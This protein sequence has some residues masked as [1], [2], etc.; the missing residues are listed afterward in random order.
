[1]RKWSDDKILEWTMDTFPHNH[2]AQMLKVEEELLE[3]EKAKR[4]VFQ[5]QAC[6]YVEVYKESADVVIAAIGLRRYP[7]YAAIGR[8]IY[9]AVY[10]PIR[11][12]LDLYID[13]KMNENLTRTFRKTKNGTQHH[14]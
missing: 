11:Q 6:N 2:E 13:E 3:L 7:R 4:A 12:A 9:N 5:S 8:A 10:T 1:M 14:I